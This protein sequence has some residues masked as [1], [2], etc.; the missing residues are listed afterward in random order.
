MSEKTARGISKWLIKWRWI[1]LALA[2]TLTVGSYFPARRLDFDR[3]VENMFAADDPLLVPYRQL[4]RTFG[5]DD[6]PV[7]PYDDQVFMTPG[8]M[9]RVIHLTEQLSAVAGV[10]SVVSLTTTPLGAKII[11]DERQ[12]PAYLDLLEGYIVSTDREM[13]AVA[14]VLDPKASS[15]ARARTVWRLQEV[16]K[17]FDSKAVLVGGS[18]MVVEG[19]RL[20]EEDGNRLGWLSTILLMIT[21]AGC[22]RSLRWVVVPIVIVNAT[23]LITKAALVVSGLRLSMASSMLWSIITVQGVATV[24]HVVVRFREAR[25]IGAAPHKAL[26]M[27]GTL[28]A[29]PIMWTCLTDAAGF[30][31]LLAAEVGPVRDFGLMMVFGSLLALVGVSLFLPGLALAGGRHVDPQWAWG[32]TRLTALLR[33]SM[34]VVLRWPKTIA[35]L[36]FLAVFAVAMGSYRLEVESDFTKNFRASSEIVT[37][38]NFVE[39]RLGGAG[40]WDVI[41]PAPPPDHLSSRYL[42]GL[43]H[44]EK[45]LRTEVTI[46]D[47][48][49]QEVPALTKVMSIVDGLDTVPTPRLARDIMVRLKHRRLQKEMPEIAEALYAEDPDQPGKYFARIM[50]RAKE[51]QSARQKQ[52]LIADVTEISRDVFPGN[53]TLARAEVTGFFV[54]LTNL[55]DSMLRDQWIT[56][57]IATGAIGLMMLVAFR[58]PVLALIALVPNILPILV[59][60]GI[61]GWLGLKINM[62]AAMIAAVSMGLSVDAGIHYVTMFRRLRNEGKSV[63]D[64]LYA[65]HQSVGRAVVFSTLALVVGFG[66]L[67]LSEFVPTIYFGALVSLSFVGGLLGNLVILPV[68]LR[69]VISDKPQNRLA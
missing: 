66:A 12:G 50:L 8:A 11:T 42:A 69:L 58:S 26:L 52:Q 19:F 37:S 61:M 36:S 6:V 62:G 29:A 35:A 63:C 56:F 15:D 59:L 65:V 13:T 67:C 38:Y 24:I 49:G 47:E 44:L 2:V 28:L 32:E 43:R 16:V 22:F 30:G 25:S 60:T 48:R 55:I 18:V 10:Q 7:A 45:R 33:R 54:L 40:V 20:I 23:L 14:C 39:S 34:D 53:E 46:T 41:V 51:R 31:S 68:L 64:A 27:A 1:L 57:A 17:A 3:S 9:L 5:G 21:I 4:K